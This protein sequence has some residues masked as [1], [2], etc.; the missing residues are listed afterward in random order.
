L[1]IVVTDYDP[2]WPTLFERIAEP[3][4]AAVVDIGAGVEHVG[5]TSVLGLRAKPVIDIDVVLR[6]EADVPTA[7][8][9]LRSLGYTY[10]GNK[11]IPGRAAFMWPD[12]APPHHL[13]T[14]IMDNQPHRD[15]IDFR[16]YLRAHPETAREYAELK[17]RLAAEHHDNRLAY[18][19]S[20]AAFTYA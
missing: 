17:E 10:Q 7:I 11:G 19:D 1:E 16:D 4:R 3:V 9:R 20:K 14:V 13:Y 5:S 12:G 18:T 8:E 15:H 2:E 6:S